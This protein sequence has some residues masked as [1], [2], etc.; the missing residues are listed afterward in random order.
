MATVATSIKY[1]GRVI[2][3]PLA[4]PDE[5]GIADEVLHENLARPTTERTKRLKRDAAGNML[6]PAN[7]SMPRSGPGLKGCA[8]SPRRTRQV[9]GNRRL[10]EERWG[11]RTS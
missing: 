10:S 2:D 6:Q 9:Q 1:D 11:W 7:L 5:N 3:F 4:N 8:S